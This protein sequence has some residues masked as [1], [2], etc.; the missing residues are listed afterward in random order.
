MHRALFELFAD[1]A[2]SHDAGALE[3]LISIGDVGKKVANELLPLSPGHFDSRYIADGIAGASLGDFRGAHEGV[4]QV[5]TDLL[6]GI[7][8]H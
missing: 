8:R 3:L 1:K 4:D 6:L 5:I 2:Y 7:G